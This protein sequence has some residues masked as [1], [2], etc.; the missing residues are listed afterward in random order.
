MSLTAE[1][2]CDR[3]A[4][5]ADFLSNMRQNLKSAL[6]TFVALLKQINLTTNSEELQPFV[7]EIL[8]DQSRAQYKSQ[9]LDYLLYGEQLVSVPEN[10]HGYFTDYGKTLISTLN[11]THN[12]ITMLLANINSYLSILI[13]NKEHHTSTKDQS[14]IYIEASKERQMLMDN[15]GAYFPK[16]TG[17][18]KQ[19]IKSVLHRFKD[20]EEM[21]DI[22]PQINTAVNKFNISQMQS[23]IQETSDMASML[24][25]YI[26]Q[27][28]IEAISPAVAKS[29]SVG[30][31]ETARYTELVSMIYF[32]TSL[33]LKA[34]SDLL[35]TILKA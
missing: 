15:I 9:Q 19:P 18:T 25:N 26:N 20:L 12:R 31:T 10:F 28:D 13:T 35:K 33:F 32:D 27:G 24:L 21:R 2:C 8:S 7:K 30:L 17:I 29:I 3:I 34:Y 14:K 16:N 5:E 6:P 22:I 11:T 4:L 1:Q 23:H